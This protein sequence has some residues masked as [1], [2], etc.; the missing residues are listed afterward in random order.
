MEKSKQI[1]F[2]GIGAPK[3][4]ST[5]ITKCLAEHP[6]ILFSSKKS[7]KEIFFFNTP[8]G[9]MWNN[10]KVGRMSYYDKGVD[11]YLEQFPEYE[12]GK[13]RGEFTTSYLSDKLA[14]KRIKEHFPNVKILV[15]LRNPIEMIYSLHWFI[16]HGAVIDIS[17]SFE[18]NLEAAIFTDKGFYHKHLSK[19]YNAFP[20]RNIKVILFDDIKQDAKE[21]IKDI[22]KFL[23]VDQGYIPDSIGKVVNSAFKPK[24]VLVK[25]LVNKSLRVIDSLHLDFLRL[26]IFESQFLQDVYTKM[27]KVQTKYPPLSKALR[28]KGI[29]IYLEDIEKLEKLI[30]RDLSDW[31]KC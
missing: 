8:D 3:S 16:Y 17:E 4:G 9:W 25:R 23:G 31:K 2:I 12:E 30:G 24:S 15:T 22:Y 5:W 6:Q 10:K 28:K 11:W 1:D 20:A 27:N 21:C 19:Y 14:C 7:R 18:D 26:K 29:E 13:K